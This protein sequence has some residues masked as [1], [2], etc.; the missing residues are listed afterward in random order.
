M[1]ETVSVRPLRLDWDKAKCTNCMSCTVVCS[2][3]HVGMS[4]PTR[5]HIRI[6]VDVLRGDYAAEYCR[7]CQPAPCAAACPTEA[8]LLDDQV[9]A[10]RVDDS[11]CVA[12]GACVE[13][14]AYHAIRLDSVSG[15]A[16]K[17]D[18]CLGAWRCVEICP[19]AALLVR[20]SELEGEPVR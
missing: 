3:R 6:L 12:C 15:L 4:A 19:T 17:C 16:A 20:E 13:A 9:R 11:L 2:E 7:Q 5:S 1:S 18:A 14:C 10:W 8:V